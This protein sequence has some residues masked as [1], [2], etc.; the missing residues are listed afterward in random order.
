MVSLEMLERGHKPVASG[1][2]LYLIGECMG[3]RVGKDVIWITAV[4]PSKKSGE[5]KLATFFAEPIRGSFAALR[6][7][8]GGS[9]A[10]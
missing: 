7:T 10:A 4:I 3:R 5:P 9:D 8:A 2:C 1:F 6:M